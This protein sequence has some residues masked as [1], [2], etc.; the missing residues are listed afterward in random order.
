MNGE[1]VKSYKVVCESCQRSDVL[2]ISEYTFDGQHIRKVDYTNHEPIISARFRPDMN[3]GFECLCGQDSRVAPQEKDA[4]H[5]LVKNGSEQ[6]I[7]AIAKSLTPRNELKF[8][9]EPA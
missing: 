1:S 5:R 8:R 4:L 2:K 9:M 6:A 3:W 7:K